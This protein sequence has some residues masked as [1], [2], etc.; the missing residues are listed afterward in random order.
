ML[1]QN[2]EMIK[3]FIDKMKWEDLIYNWNSRKMK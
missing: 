2:A 3:N 1:K